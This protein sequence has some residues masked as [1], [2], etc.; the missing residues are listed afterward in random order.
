MEV[1]G[2]TTLFAQA[3]GGVAITPETKFIPGAFLVALFDDSE[4]LTGANP[5]NGFT[6]IDAVTPARF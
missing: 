1:S 5:T 4:G 3:Q 6:G 2:V